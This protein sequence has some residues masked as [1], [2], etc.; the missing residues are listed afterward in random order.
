MEQLLRLTQYTLAAL[1]S[2]GI[3]AVAI[4]GVFRSRN[5]PHVEETTTV[6]SLPQIPMSEI[7]SPSTQ[8]K[9]ASAGMAPAEPS[10]FKVRGVLDDDNVADDCL[11]LAGLSNN[12]F[13]E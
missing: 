6:D 4:R 1:V 3:L 10:L 12:S 7:G 11:H 5:K 2:V 9:F 13:V 8:L